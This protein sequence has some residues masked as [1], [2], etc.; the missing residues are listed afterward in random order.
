MNS[1]FGQCA[2]QPSSSQNSHGIFVYFDQ[3]PAASCSCT[4]SI[5]NSVG[6][7]SG[8]GSSSYSR[9]VS[10]LRRFTELRVICFGHLCPQ[11]LC[12][13]C[14]YRCLP[15]VK[16]VL[17]PLVPYADRQLAV[18]TL[19]NDVLLHPFASAAA[20]AKP[21]VRLHIVLVYRTVRRR[22]PLVRRNYK[23]LVS[24]LSPCLK[25]NV[26]AE[27]VLCPFL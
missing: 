15:K 14:H 8:L 23:R 6:G 20:L 2:V 27:G 26:S 21:S 19:D 17:N 4:Y 22:C 24:Q 16:S 25:G 9:S 13:F 3:T 1:I 5:A 7:V 11:R 10:V 18:R 12:Q